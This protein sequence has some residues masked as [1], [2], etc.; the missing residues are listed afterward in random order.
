MVSVALGINDTWRRYDS[1]LPTT[2]E[3]YGDN[4]RTILSAAQR[5]GAKL[6]VLS[7][8]ALSGSSVDITGWHEQDLNDKIAM[9]KQVA[10]EFGALYIPMDDIFRKTY[11]GDASYTLDRYPP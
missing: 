10:E 7:P 1:N 2:A 3:E 9:C 6:V 4:L 5:T 11:G 8:F